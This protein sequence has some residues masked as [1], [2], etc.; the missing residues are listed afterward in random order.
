M[1]LIHSVGNSAHAAASVG[2]QYFLLRICFLQL[3]NKFTAKKF[4]RTGR[5]MCTTPQ[6]SLSTPTNGS[7]DSHRSKY[8]SGCS[9]NV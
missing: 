7:L 6:F 3:W 4:T 2:V 5:N 9:L 8:C 1:C